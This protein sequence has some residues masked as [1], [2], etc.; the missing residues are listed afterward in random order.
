MC[1]DKNR[2]GLSTDGPV[3]MWWR[4]RMGPGQCLGANCSIRGRPWKEQVAMAVC[5][6]VSGR[7][8]SNDSILANAPIYTEIGIKQS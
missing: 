2:L 3:I 7:S 5:V 6:L 4:T 1:R 8:I